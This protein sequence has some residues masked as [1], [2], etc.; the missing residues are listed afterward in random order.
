VPFDLSRVLFISTANYADPIPRPLLD[1]ME[2]IELAG[3]TL[4]EKLNIARRYLVPR[5]LEENGLK[6]DQ[7]QFDDDALE[8]IISRYTRE[9]G[10][11]N[12]ERTIGSVCRARAASI[13]RGQRR[14]ARVTRR[15][16]ETDLGP[17]EFEPQS[18]ARSSIPGVVTG[19]AYTPTGGEILFI[20]ATR[21]PGNGNL[22]VTGQLGNVMRESSQAAFSIVR[23]QAKSL[24][25]DPEGVLRHDYHIHVPAGAVQKDGPSAGVAM[26]VAL[27]SLLTDRPVDPATGMTGEITLRGRVLPIG[28]VRDKVLAAHRAGLTRVILPKHNARD[29]LEIPADTRKELRFVYVQTIEQVLKAAFDTAIGKRAK[30]AGRAKAV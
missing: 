1:R 10:V 19:L 14:S 24:G 7:L 30:G 17:V 3:Y 18:A 15:S 25:I 8:H 6:P 21:M 29:L 2:V 27:V 4:H 28:G 5:Q 16:L 13:V 26:L 11:R 23:S 9:A 22:N 20:E 12:L